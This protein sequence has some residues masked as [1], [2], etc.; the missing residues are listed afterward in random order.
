MSTVLAGLY[1]RGLLGAD[2]RQA[3]R[4]APASVISEV[5]AEAAR[6]SAITCGRRGADPPT[7]AELA[8]SPVT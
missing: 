2:R 3:L 8:A 5:C 1:E 4:S 6:A 7:R